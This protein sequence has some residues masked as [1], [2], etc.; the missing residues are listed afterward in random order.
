V[1]LLLSRPERL[2]EMVR[3]YQAQTQRFLIDHR[4]QLVIVESPSA[5]GTTP[6]TMLSAWCDLIVHCDI[7]HSGAARNAGIEAVKECG[8]DIVCFWDD[9]DWYGPE[10]VHEAA[11]ALETSG[12]TVVGKQYHYIDFEGQHLF[13]FNVG[14]AERFCNSVIGPTITVRVEDALPFESRYL[15]D[16]LWCEAM[17]EKGATFWSTSMNHYVHHRHPDNYT[18]RHTVESLVYQRGMGSYLGAPD[19][20]FATGEREAISLKTVRPYEIWEPPLHKS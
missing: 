2:A 4:S 10:Y 15:D 19:L 12:A 18:G 1:V 14:Y 11:T 13:R 16:Y 9:D 6:R 20:A 3:Q 8:G 17:R 7:P 5:R